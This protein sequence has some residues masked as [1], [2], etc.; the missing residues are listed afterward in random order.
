M[1]SDSRVGW[2]GRGILIKQ[3]AGIDLLDAGNVIMCG[4]VVVRDIIVRGI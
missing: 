1:S 2:S 3:E 4:G